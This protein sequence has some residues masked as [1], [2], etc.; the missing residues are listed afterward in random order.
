MDTLKLAAATA[1]AAAEFEI[2]VG[3]DPARAEELKK[4]AVVVKIR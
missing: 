4:Q 1:A 3:F 2:T